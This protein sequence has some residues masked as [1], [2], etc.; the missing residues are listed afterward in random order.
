[1]L[2]TFDST[3]R[4]RAA[5]LLFASLIAG[6]AI[7]GCGRVRYLTSD[8]S[9]DAHD[10]PRDT[11]S[12]DAAH[13][14]AARAD[15]ASIDVGPID[16]GEEPGFDTGTPDT[17]VDASVP[18]DTGHDAS[19]FDAFVPIDARDGCFH[20]SSPVGIVRTS[21]HGALGTGEFTFEAWVRDPTSL[22]GASVVI[23][24]R[25]RPGTSFEGYLFGLLYGRTFVQLTD[26]P[27]HECGPTL[28]TDGL[29]HHIAFWRDSLG[30]L[31]CSVDFVTY[32]P[33]VP[34]SSP[35][36]LP[37]VL[38]LVVGDD[39]SGVSAAFGG[40]IQMARTWST[41]RD[42]AGLRA[43]AYTPAAGTSGLAF[44]AWFA[45]PPSDLAQLYSPTRGTY[46]ERLMVEA[47]WG[48]GCPVE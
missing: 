6:V 31:G 34:T 7:T 47:R 38:D 17:G 35:R 26:T 44:E 8:A 39:S 11:G 25:R 15:A 10:V 45:G 30:S 41:R 1:M 24:N 33:D 3:L 22:T 46:D 2:R 9:L 36:S 14:D 42:V 19:S 23:G 16:G 37:A 13:M 32:T 43:T 27:N 12:L 5:W 40:D 20:L 48:T 4:G 21:G 29:W 18:P 28:T